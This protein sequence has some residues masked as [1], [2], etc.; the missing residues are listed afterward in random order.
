MRWRS[1]ASAAC[2]IPLRALRLG[3]RSTG[4][5]GGAEA[6]SEGATA[7]TL[8]RAIPVISR[9]TACRA[10]T[11]TH[12]HRRSLPIAASVGARHAVPQHWPQHRH[13]DTDDQS[14]YRGM[15]SAQR[16]AV[17]Q[18]LARHAGS[19]PV[20]DSRHRRSSPIA[21]SVG[22]RHA[23]PQHCAPTLTHRH[24]RSS[25]IAA[26]VGARQCRAPT[27]THRHRR[28]SPIAASVGA[29]H[30]PCRCAAT[31]SHRSGAQHHHGS[32]ASDERR[33]GDDASSDAG[34][35]VRGWSAS[36][37]VH[38][39]ACGVCGGFGG[40]RR[41]VNHCL[42]CLRH[43]RLPGAAV[44]Q[45][46]RLARQVCDRLGA[47]LGSVGGADGVR[48]PCDAEVRRMLCGA[49]S[50]AQGDYQGMNH[51]RLPSRQSVQRFSAA[52]RVMSRE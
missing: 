26:S 33:I 39:V 47:V 38:R 51:N 27:L 22:A 14:R 31:A 50:D 46:R 35:N 42:R 52:R 17:P 6:R 13:T 19:G 7:A 1:A 20:S 4:A 30:A 25:P 12:R 11:L 32:I 16:H 48:R 23:V 37:G 10:P 28:S 41:R 15:Q 2:A 44:R 43:T 3:V 18:R 9:G 29:R 8:R 40:Q 5:R 21:A 45:R 49:L 34:G 24:R 36:S